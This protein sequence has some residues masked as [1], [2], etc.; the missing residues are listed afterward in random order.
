MNEFNAID[1]IAMA[2]GYIT[3]R[4]R[5]LWD[6]QARRTREPLS[7][8]GVD[9]DLW[10][11]VGE[12]EAV[13][14]TAVAIARAL[15]GGVPGQGLLVLDEPTV[16]LSPSE[17][18][19]LLRIVK[20]LADS[21]VAVLYVSHYLD[22]VL[23]IAQRVTV[24]RNGKLV[25]SRT[26]D[27]L[28]KR[29]LI[30]LMIGTDIQTMANG[31]AELAALGGQDVPSA[32]AL[33]ARNLRGRE[34][35]GLSF[36]VYPGEILGIAGT[37]G[38]GRTELPLA[39]VGAAERCS[40]D[41]SVGTSE[42]RRRT[43][44]AMKE[45]GVVLVP[46]DRHRQGS[47]AEFSVTEN[48]TL[49]GLGRFRRRGRLSHAA[50]RAYTVGWLE[51]LD[52]R[53]PRPDLIFSTLS[54]G[55]QQKVV[56]GK[57]LGTKPTVLVLDEPTSGVDVEARSTI[58]RIIRDQ[59]AAGLAIVACSSDT[60]ELVELATRVIVLRDGVAAVELSS[61]PLDEAAILH[62]M[63]PGDTAASSVLKD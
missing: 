37:L 9:V 57:W 4:H 16:A 63:E 43:T 62:A 24:L 38:S 27:G 29:E 19:R 3:R 54:G 14:R 61:L 59:A 40:G 31:T 7:T 46:G 33:T 11:P 10:R 30:R 26:A 53:P 6:R 58:Y 55:N 41:V 32:P 50:E 42:T 2:G 48:A 52:V 21:G 56:V 18:Q 45:L 25:T 51:R 60:E 5:I 39:L 20:G 23:Q 1:N 12:F 35:R 47:I 22:E 8:V 15:A 13:E 28:D 34:L 36:E 44:C 17:I 49:A